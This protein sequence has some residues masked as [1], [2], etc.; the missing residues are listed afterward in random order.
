M[1]LV[2]TRMTADKF[3]LV[4]S[5]NQFT[6]VKTTA[7]AYLFRGGRKKMQRAELSRQ[8]VTSRVVLDL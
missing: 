7:Q 8:K 5:F 6:L 1:L 3:F 4:K 2:P